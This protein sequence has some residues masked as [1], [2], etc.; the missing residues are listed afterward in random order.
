[1]STIIIKPGLGKLDEI[2]SKGVLATISFW[3]KIGFNANLI[4]T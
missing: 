4:T 1:M 3:K 2:F